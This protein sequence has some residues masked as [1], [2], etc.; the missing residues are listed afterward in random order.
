MVS[1]DLEAWISHAYG[2]GPQENLQTSRSEELPR[3]VIFCVLLHIVTCS[4]NKTLLSAP[5]PR[6]CFT[7]FFLQ[8]ILTYILLL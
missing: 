7:C 5:A 3:W 2:M 6:L 4:E 1:V 8:L